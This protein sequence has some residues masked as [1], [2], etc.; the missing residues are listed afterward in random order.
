MPADIGQ[1]LKPIRKRSFEHH[2]AE[3]LLKS[4]YGSHFL[5]GSCIPDVEQ[6]FFLILDKKRNARNDVINSDRGHSYVA[7]GH[8][9]FFR[10]AL[11]SQNRRG[12]GFT[13]D[14]GKVRPNGVV[15]KCLFRAHIASSIPQTLMAVRLMP[16][17]FSTKPPRAMI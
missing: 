5:R 4:G 17:R 12:L 8:R 9:F 13:R 11:K 10:Q 1:V 16:Y 3:V 7:N 15:K 14:S 2:G 6:N